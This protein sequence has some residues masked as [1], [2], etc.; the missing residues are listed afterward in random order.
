MSDPMTDERALALDKLC[1]ELVDKDIVPLLRR[2]LHKRVSLYLEQIVPKAARLK[3]AQEPVTQAVG[4]ETAV[5][6]ERCDADVYKYGVSLGLFQMTKQEAEDYC[7]AETKR[8]GRRH[9]WHFVGGRAHVKA[10]DGRTPPPPALPEVDAVLAMLERFDLAY[11]Q[12]G[13][14][15]SARPHGTYVRLSDVKAAIDGCRAR[16]MA[17]AG[18]DRG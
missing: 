4:Q 18:G 1:C 12:Y 6:S 7:V 2:V 3:A 14:C 13:A 15:I 5:S 16:L 10:L 17:K 9:D 11:S 8:T